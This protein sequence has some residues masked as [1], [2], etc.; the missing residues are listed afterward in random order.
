MIGLAAG[1]GLM[2]A[3]HAMMPKFHPIQQT[4]EAVT[5]SPGASVRFAYAEDPGYFLIP[6]LPTAAA[7]YKIA[8]GNHEVS[9]VATYD[10]NHLVDKEPVIGPLSDEGDYNLT[11]V[12]YICAQPGVADCAKL[13]LSQEIKVDRNATKGEERIP[14]NLSDLAREGLQAG[15]GKLPSLDD[16]EKAPTGAKSE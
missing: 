4:L 13:D 2:M 15:N 3:K 5:L 9:T 8:E 10:Y 12:L 7:L 11:A 6:G 14:F 1:I 16:P